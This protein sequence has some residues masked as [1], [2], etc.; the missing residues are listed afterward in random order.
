M[1]FHLYGRVAEICLVEPN[2]LNRNET[3]H[4][5]GW[6]WIW[7]VSGKPRS[8]VVYDIMR[9]AKHSYHYAVCSCKKS[10]KL[11]NRK[12]LLTWGI[13]KKSGRKLKRLIL[14]VKLYLT[15]S[16][17]RTVL[18]IYLN[19]FLKS[20]ARYTTVFRLMITN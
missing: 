4:F 9:R 13:F 16:V 10:L 3:G 18:K 12:Y 15:Q 14:P 7:C 19:C 6:H 1:V 2:M 20:I 5:S 11:R 8:G 17:K